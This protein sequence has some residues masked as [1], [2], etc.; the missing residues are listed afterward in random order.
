MEFHKA[1][2]RISD[3]PGIK[4]IKMRTSETIVCNQ[5]RQRELAI[6][7]AQPRP[8]SRCNAGR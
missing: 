2:L 7:A 1:F 3:F 8:A 4:I 6:K 5:I